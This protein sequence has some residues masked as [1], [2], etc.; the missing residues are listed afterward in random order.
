NDMEVLISPCHCKGSLEFVHMQCL[1]KWL[2]ACG[3]TICELCR[4]Q[5]ETT[6]ERRFGLMESL[7][8]WYRHPLNRRLL[9][10]DILLC[11][12]LTIIGFGMTL[13]CALGIH[14][15]KYKTQNQADLPETWTLGLLWVFLIIVV[16]SYILNIS[17]VVRSQVYPWYRWWQNNRRVKLQI[18]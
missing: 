3:S 2:N 12:L 7:R 1:E 8:I 13:I 16:A 6:S 17:L 18:V 9:G 5:Y 15:F 4:Y 10:T 11:F 14:Y